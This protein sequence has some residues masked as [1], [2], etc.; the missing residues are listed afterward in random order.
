MRGQGPSQECSDCLTH[1]A[2]EAVIQAAMIAEGADEHLQARRFFDTDSWDAMS[3]GNEVDHFLRTISQLLIS[4]AGKEAD[5]LRHVLVRHTR[6]MLAK[7]RGCWIRGPHHAL[8]GPGT[9]KNIGGE[10]LLQDGQLD[11]SDSVCC[12]G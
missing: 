7:P 6:G 4:E 8:G 1:V 10:M 11:T 3:V 2:P 9:V 12:T 5:C